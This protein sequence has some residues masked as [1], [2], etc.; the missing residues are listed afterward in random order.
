MV[1]IGVRVYT[2]PASTSNSHSYLL[3]SFRGGLTEPLE[4]LTFDEIRVPFE[5]FRVLI[6]LKQDKLVFG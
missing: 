5:Y 4:H 6:E 3:G 1:R 2:C